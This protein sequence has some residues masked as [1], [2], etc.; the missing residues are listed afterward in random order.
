MRQPGIYEER[1]FH[2]IFLDFKPNASTNLRV[3]E[4]LGAV[5][6]GAQ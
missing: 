6:N 1:L 5:S 3:V 4:E 2:P